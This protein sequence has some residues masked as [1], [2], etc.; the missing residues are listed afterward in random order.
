M[1][2]DTVV[3]IHAPRFRG[4]MRSSRASKT[5]RTTFQ[6]T[7]PVSGERCSFKMTIS[8]SERSFNP[9]S[10]FPG[11]DARGMEMSKLGEKFQST[12]PV[13]GERCIAKSATASPMPCF[14]PRSPFPGSDASQEP[15]SSGAAHVSIHAPRFRGAMRQTTTVMSS[16][17][18]FQSTLPVSGERC[19]PNWAAPV[20]APSFQSTLPVSGE[21][22]AD[23]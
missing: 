9:R 6:S 8:F 16:S 15:Q 1:A 23:Q 11:S 14:N 20:A 4:A 3:S 22:C 18:R 7:L 17:R 13:S 2:G 19:P 10:P 12:L 21:R 5:S